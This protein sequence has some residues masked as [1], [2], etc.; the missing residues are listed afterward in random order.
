[1]DNRSALQRWVEKLALFFERPF[2][3]FGGTSLNLFYHTDTLAVFL[4]LV[5]AFSGLYLTFFYQFGF[6][7]SYRAVAKMESQVLA[8]IVRAIHRYASASAMIVT[9]LH[10]LRLFFM[11]RFRGARWLAWVSGV[12]MVVF[13][14]LE[15][16]T[17][18][19]LVWDQRAQLITSSFRAVLGRFA[20]AF[21]SWMLVAGKNDQSWILMTILLFLHVL[22]FGLIALFFW[23][24][25]MRLQRPRFLPARYWLVGSGLVL[26]LVSALFPL[27]MLPKTDFGWIPNGISLD[28]FFL[29][30]IPYTLSPSAIWIWVGLGLVALVLGLVP[31]ISLGK[32]IAPI[33]IHP[34]NCTGCTLCSKDCPYKA[35]SMLERAPGTGHKFLAKVDAKLCVGCGVCLGSCE[36][37]AISLNQLS[38]TVIW[39]SVEARLARHSQQAATICFTCERHA[40]QGA[41]PYLVDQPLNQSEVEVIPVPCVAVLPPRLIARVMAGGAGEVRVVGCPPGDCSR[42]EGN[43]WAEERLNRTRLP[44]L[45]KA[46]EDAPIYTFWL[47]PD[48]FSQS[49]P[50]LPARAGQPVGEG[51]KPGSTYRPV[52]A[53]NHFAIA[54]GVLALLLAGQIWLTQVWSPRILSVPQAYVQLVMP[55]PGVLV[56]TAERYA[57]KFGELPTRLVL[58]DG[59]KVLLDRPY[60]FAEKDKNSPLVLEFPAGLA[61]HDFRVSLA[62][63]S[64]ANRLDYYHRA[65]SLESGQVWIIM[66]DQLPRPK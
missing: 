27:G 3:T 33:E 6:D 20:P 52:L 57:Q 53:W 35:I 63:V 34:E 39:Q 46:L 64:S 8:H 38:E 66:V 47:P 23:W 49:L 1:M 5:V 62:G 60:P 44:R 28:P 14:W 18:Y 7:A 12:V 40:A 50:V 29:L 4:W 16:L 54:F 59:E 26:V 56:F 25:I 41:R 21:F 58:L 61:E 55:D 51:A 48:Q 37:E 2:N 31:W 43:L 9:V 65:V 30:M 13:L 24:H 17:G 11:D 45:K 15:G 36:T 22:L 42:R 32:P 10:G 19:W